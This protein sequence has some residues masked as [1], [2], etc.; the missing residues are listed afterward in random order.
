MPISSASQLIHFR[1][2]ASVEKSQVAL[3]P[4]TALQDG[5][6][7]ARGSKRL[8]HLQPESTQLAR[9]QQ[10]RQPSGEHKPV[11]VTQRPRQW[12]RRPKDVPHSGAPGRPMSTP[13]KV[14]VADVTQEVPPPA[15]GYAKARR[16]SQ[17]PRPYGNWGVAFGFK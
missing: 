16:A 12:R 17:Q 10:Y 2:G 9:S 5:F 8:R 7:D 3:S 15:G 6:H 13:T 4:I 1:C 11:H 14:R